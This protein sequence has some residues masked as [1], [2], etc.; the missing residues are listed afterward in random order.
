MTQVGIQRSHSWLINCCSEPKAEAVLGMY[1]TVAT[2]N[3]FHPIFA[4][5][6]ADC[7]FS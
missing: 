1:G 5:V 4:K 2:H 6:I 3:K 7:S